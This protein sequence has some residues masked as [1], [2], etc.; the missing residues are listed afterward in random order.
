MWRD[1]LFANGSFTP[2]G[3]DTFEVRIEYLDAA[4]S[5]TGDERFSVIV[6]RGTADYAWVLT[7][8]EQ[9]A[10]AVPALSLDG[11]T[12]TAE[13]ELYVNDPPTLGLGPINLLPEGSKLTPF[14]LTATCNP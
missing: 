9:F 10:D 6:R 3:G 14:S 1:F 7:Y 11:T 5:N 2:T 13:G 8:A 4:T 12:L